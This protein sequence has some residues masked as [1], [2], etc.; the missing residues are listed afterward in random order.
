MMMS[1]YSDDYENVLEL[2]YSAALTG[3][4]N[5]SPSVQYISNPGGDRTV[6][7]AVVLGLRLQMI[8]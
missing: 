3:W 6:S 7:D 5:I 2:Y 8:F 4:L 1:S